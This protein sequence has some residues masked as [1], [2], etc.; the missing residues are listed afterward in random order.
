MIFG[1][2]QTQHFLTFSWWY[3]EWIPTANPGCH[4][5]LARA[6]T[7]H[8]RLFATYP[9][10]AAASNK[11]PWPPMTVSAGGTW[12][13]RW[14]WR[15]ID[16]YTHRSR[17]TRLPVLCSSRR[18]FTTKSGQRLRWCGRLRRRRQ[19]LTR[20]VSKRNSSN[21]ANLISRGAAGFDTFFLVF[22][23]PIKSNSVL[24]RGSN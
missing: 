3:V 13:S 12:F 9:L 16:V 5:S 20:N 15:A 17:P 19:R 23:F 6:N 8:R 24:R 10:F 1:F 2:S 22:L 7:F 4:I 14:L 21:C 11:V 18:I